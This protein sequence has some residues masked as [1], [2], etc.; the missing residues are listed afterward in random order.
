[1]RIWCAPY[2]F[3]FMEHRVRNVLAVIASLLFCMSPA[4]LAEGS[5]QGYGM[6]G[7]FEQYAPVV[8]RYNQSGELFRITGHCQSACTLFL[9]IR[10]VCI[11]PSARLLFHA[12]H[13]RQRNITAHAT[14]RML[15]AY[16]GSLRNYLVSKGYMSTLA[17]HTISGQDMISKFGYRAC[18]GRA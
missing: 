17:F 12:G 2:A 18:P 6:G 9:G 1:M 16:N 10:N 4:A 14:N 15:A 3:N 11:E 7:W 8:E 13:D 5:S